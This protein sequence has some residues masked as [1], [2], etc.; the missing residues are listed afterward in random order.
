MSS[1]VRFPSR[2]K[3]LRLKQGLSQEY[4]AAM[5][6]MS[7]RH[8]VRIENG[9]TEPSASKLQNIARVLGYSMEELLQLEGGREN[10]RQG[11]ISKPG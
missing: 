11:E 8:Y 9:Q 4:I 7:W 10:G 1:S 5:A 3:Q 6:R 2:I